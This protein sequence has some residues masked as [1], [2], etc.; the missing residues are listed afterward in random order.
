[1]SRITGQAEECFERA[2]TCRLLAE[3]ISFDEKA[4]KDFADMAERW[5]T[6][7]RSYALAEEISG[8]IEWQ[9]KR[10]DPPPGFEEF[11]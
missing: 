1:M 8:F 9:A 3:D 10:L 2:R 7:A 4:R 11:S 5:L 6:L